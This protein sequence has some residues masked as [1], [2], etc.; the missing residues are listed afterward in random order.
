MGGIKRKNEDGGKDVEYD[1]EG[2]RITLIEKQIFEVNVENLDEDMI[3]KAFDDVSGEN[4][5]PK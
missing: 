3:R 2:M 5:D 1:D 4:L